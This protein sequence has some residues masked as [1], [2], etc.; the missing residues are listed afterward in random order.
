M[1][2]KPLNLT[3]SEVRAVLRE[4]KSPGSGKS[5]FRKV[6]NP[7]PPSDYTFLGVYAPK[8]SAV[9]EGLFFLVREDIVITSPYSPGDRIWCKERAVVYQDGEDRKCIYVADLPPE[10]T[11]ASPLDKYMG[12]CWKSLSSARM[13][14]WASRLTLVVESVVPQRLQDI[15]EE[16]ARAEGIDWPGDNVECCG[17]P[18]VD[19]DFTPH[20]EPINPREECCGNPVPSIGPLEAYRDTWNA[21]N[22]K[23][24]Y[25]SNDWV[26]K[27]TFRPYLCNI[28]EMEK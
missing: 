9:F 19:C 6:M 4:I 20:G 27:Y 15:T 11:K 24:P 3:A 14:R 5:Q 17:M 26:W 13:P 28:D 7:Q 12:V 1:T 10:E 2:D 21:R 25:E 23:H 18:H 8:I 22:P 16:D